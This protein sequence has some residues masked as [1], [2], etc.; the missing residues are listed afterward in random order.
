LVSVKVVVSV[1]DVMVM[2]DVAV[3]VVTVI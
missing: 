1:V 3:L 2:L